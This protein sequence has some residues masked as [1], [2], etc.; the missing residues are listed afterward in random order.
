MADHHNGASLLGSDRVQDGGGGVVVHAGQGIVQNQHR[1][2]HQQGAPQGSAL[3]LPAAERDA[4]FADDGAESIREPF[5]VI[6]QSGTFGRLLDPVISCP[7]FA[8]TKVVGEGAGEQKSLLGNHGH[9][10]SQI[11]QGQAVDVHAIQEQLT[12]RNGHHPTEG[13]GQGCFA[14]AHSTN[15][16]HQFAGFNAEIKAVQ[17]VALGSV[18]TDAQAA[19]F[20]SSAPRLFNVDRI[21]AITNGRLSLEQLLHPFQT[22]LAGLERVEREAQQRSG[23]N[24]LLHIEDQGDKPAGREA[25]VA[26][27]AAAQGQQ[28]QQGDGGKPLQQREERASS[29]CQTD[30]AVSVTAVA[31]GKRLLLRCF[32][33]VDLDCSDAGEVLLDQIAQPGQVL[34]LTALLLHHSAAEQAHHREHHGVGTNS[35]QGQPRIN[36]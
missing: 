20:E 7:G 12:V 21:V 19:S 16:G 24:Q 31:L 8:V 10:A 29:P 3:T 2:R 32:L 23:K 11:L 15:H 6:R 30:G 28:Q 27:L 34:L 36:R 35:S 5:D 9:L 1:S 18:V 22:H 33:A 26:E 25:A 4:P 13:T 14:A 17:G